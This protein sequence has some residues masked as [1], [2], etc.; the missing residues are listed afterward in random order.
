M[1]SPTERYGRRWG[2]GGGG[3]GGGGER[4]AERWGEE[5][6]VWSKG[7]GDKVRARAVP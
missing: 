2:E 5:G 3:G 6:G 1:A 7:D 4:A